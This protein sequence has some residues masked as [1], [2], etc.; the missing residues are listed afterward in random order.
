MLCV[1]DLSNSMLHAGS[2]GS[3]TKAWARSYL[4]RCPRRTS[5]MHCCPRHALRRTPSA[6]C[7]SW[8]LVRTGGLV[9][10]QSLMLGLDHT[11]GIP[12]RPTPRGDIVEFDGLQIENALQFRKVDP[13]V[14][15]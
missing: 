3:I 12:P 1:T 2:H 13:S 8:K 9:K 7:S 6:T 11:V 4:S 15:V 14:P 5:V 10:S